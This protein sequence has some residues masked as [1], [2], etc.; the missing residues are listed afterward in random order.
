VLVGINLLREGLDIP[1]VSLVAIFDADK[2][3]FLRSHVSLIQTIGR[4]ARNLNGRVI[5]YAEGMTDSMKLALE[6]TNRRREVQR[7]YNEK[8][9]ITPRAVKS[10]ILDLS[11]HL[12]DADPSE[13]P[14]A[15]DSA[16]DV[17]E[18]KEL[19]RLIGELTQDMIHYADQMQFEKAAELRDRIQL[20]KDMELGLK[21]PSRS[22]LKA[23]LKPADEKKPGTPGPRGGG[24][25]R[26]GPSRGKGTGGPP[27]GKTGIGPRR[28]R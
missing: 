6:E 20:L 2:E 12:Y 23:P 25:K 26:G 16:N 22:L 10:H 28:S 14:M 9:G 4:A 3:G 1:E 5:M 11:E 17:L 7:A 24:G 27:H 8:H 21:P 19:K 13:L 15:A 18:P